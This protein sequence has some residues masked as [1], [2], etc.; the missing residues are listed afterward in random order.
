MTEIEKPSSYFRREEIRGLF[1]LG[2]LAVVASMR[3]QSKEMTIIIA[4]KSYDVSIFLDI[5]LIFWGF[6][7]FFMVLGFSEDIIGK[8]SSSMFREISTKYLYFSFVILGGLLI[9]FFLAVY[10]TRAPWVLGFLPVLFAYWLIR[11]LVKMKRPRKVDLGNLWRQ[12]KSNAYQLFLAFFQVCL[13]LV[14]FGTYEELVVPSFIVGSVFLISFLIA[15]EKVKG[16]QEEKTG[17][18]SHDGDYD[19]DY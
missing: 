11:K 5:M 19:G 3:I 15:R 13:L 7:A 6:Y 2:L 10:P 9:V 18:I 8:K 12:T 1:V 16:S 4:E 17:N 14:M